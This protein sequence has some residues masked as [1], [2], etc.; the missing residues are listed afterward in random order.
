[1]CFCLFWIIKSELYL[2]IVWL[3]ADGQLV[4][5]GAIL[6]LVFVGRLSLIWRIGCLDWVLILFFILSLIC[7]IYSLL[8]PNFISFVYLV[9]SFC[10]E[11]LW[12]SNR[13]ICHF[14]LF[15][16]LSLISHNILIVIL[17]RLKILCWLTRD[18]W[19]IIIDNVMIGHTKAP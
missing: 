4:L 17:W 2:Y 9:G 16:S 1:V 3:L 13:I 18:Y 15:N 11:S 7:M 8:S 19:T 5:V 14:F 12:Q 6:W 10:F